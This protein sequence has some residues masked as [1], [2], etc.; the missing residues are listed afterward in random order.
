MTATAVR[1]RRR[2][3]LFTLYE[4]SAQHRLY[5]VI[6][7]ACLAIPVV[8]APYLLPSFRVSQLAQ[9]AAWAVAILGMNMVIG[10][11]GLISLGHIA[12]VG[13]GAYTTTILINDNRWDLWMTLPVAF[14][15]CF[16]FGAL[17]GLPALKIR[18]L[19]LA[20]VT[21]ALAYTFP[22]LLKIDQGGIARRTG[23]DNGRNL[24]EKLIPT[25]WIRSLLNL[26]GRNEPAQVAIY[27]YFVMV[28][29]AA[30][31]FLLVRNIMKSRAGRAMIAMRDNQT[32][33]AVSGVPLARQK[34]LT[35][36]VSAAFAGIG[37]SMIAA[38]LD[39][40][41]PTTFDFNYAIL[42]LMGLVLAG[43]A[44]LHGC[45]LGGLLV[46]FLQ[47]FAPRWVTKV[48]FVHLDVIY[49]GALFGLVL[50]LVPF[51]MPAG[52]VAF[53]KKLKARLLRVVPI[54]PRPP[55]GV[56]AEVRP[57]PARRE[58]SSTVGLGQ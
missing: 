55:D 1:R 51:L 25:S 10:Y 26:N 54:V 27:K 31:C 17:V 34:V 9:S 19:Y 29:V 42:T 15:I 35:F 52:I 37:G 5:Q 49:A 32:G 53:V 22:I 16:V 21:I 56:V 3:P 23:A 4:G 39:S 8:I 44:T 30:V 45:W 28:L 6:G 20:L 36:A 18:G 43:V 12:F 24:S 38:V 46:V 50:V 11:S 48:P 57:A 7:W 58:L 14:A 47:D 41:G 13:L 2:G 33:A 40:V